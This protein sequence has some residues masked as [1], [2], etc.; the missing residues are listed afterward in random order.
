MCRG[1]PAISDELNQASSLS[2]GD[3]STGPDLDGIRNLRNEIPL[4]IRIPISTDTMDETQLDQIYY[5]IR[6]RVLLLRH[7]SN[8]VNDLCPVTPLCPEMKRLWRHLNQCSDS[9]CRYT[10]CSSSKQILLH[11]KRCRSHE[12]P[13]CPPIRLA[14]RRSIQDRERRAAH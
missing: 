1:L 2:P 12:C 7:A 11:F 3:T 10:W 14:I 8:C 6:H 9:A 5:R 13:I 4:T